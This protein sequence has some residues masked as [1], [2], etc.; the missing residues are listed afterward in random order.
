MKTR[1]H[2]LYESSGDRQPHGCSHIRLLRPLA[3]P[4]VKTIDLSW[5]HDLPTFR[6]DVVVIERTWRSDITLETQAQL[7]QH[8]KYLKLPYI[9][10]IDDN[11][12]DLPEDDGVIRSRGFTRHQIVSRFARD[13]ALVLVSS[14]ALRA[15]LAGLNGN[16]RVIP[17]C[18]DEQLFEQKLQYSPNAEVLKNRTPLV[19]GYMGTY[20]HLDDLLMIIEPL[21]EFLHEYRDAVKL[22]LIGIADAK[23]IQNL[24]RDLPVANVAIP[25]G[26]GEYTK[27]MQ[28]MTNSVHWDFGIAPL[29]ENAFNTCKSDLK[30]LDYAIHRIPGIFSATESYRHTVVHN[31]NGLLASNE[32]DWRTHLRAMTDPM[33][34]RRLAEEAQSYVI[35]ERLLS[36]NAYLWEEMAEGVALLP[37]KK[38]TRNARPPQNSSQIGPTT[39]NE[40][41]LSLV[42]IA[43]LGLEIG[44]SFAPVIPRSQG[45]NSHVLDHASQAELREKYKN[46]PGVDISKIEDVD[47]VWR[48]ERLSEL[49]GGP[50]KYD[51][52]IASHVIE[53]TPDLVGFLQQCEEILKPGGIL[54]LV[55]P[56]KRFCFDY[57]RGISTTG[58]VI[59]AHWEKRKVHT[60]GVVF[61]HF[62]YQ[63]FLDNRPS[64][65]PGQTG[66]ME[67]SVSFDEA[68]RMFD[69]A[70]DQNS[71]MDVHN[72]RFTPSSFRLI[73]DDLIRLNLL[74]FSVAREYP[75][76]GC[77]FF[78]SFLKGR[79][80]K[81][82]KLDRFYLA[83]RT[84]E[85]LSFASD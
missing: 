8:L 75:T 19:L 27:F 16:I 70:K 74:N 14:N 36:K 49:V 10:S 59:Q 9:Y 80:T 41:I 50:E 84:A 57:F 37:P 26:M 76:A 21:R 45:F 62:A 11:L 71:Y 24:F 77:E 22:E 29:V 81:H 68:A 60:P 40:K 39:R 33:V 1:V 69:L 28:W 6:V 32:S 2:V 67:L 82:S 5:G 4:S 78:V 73:F 48:G 65:G 38:A 7:L 23:L 61:D 55:V 12:L 79:G 13:A 51:Y 44:P 18:L 66:H 53:H 3:H 20:S 17:N 56:D 31:R 34:R 58:D 54:S 63:V 64:W 83:K 72:W 35:D 25:S 46:A 42:N 43:G 47:F 15:R 52:V 30:F 85:E